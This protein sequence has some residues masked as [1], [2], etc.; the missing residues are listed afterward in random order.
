[1]RRRD[2]LKAMVGGA[3]A[4]GLPL[5]KK[6]QPHTGGVVRF[7]PEKDFVAYPPEAIVSPNVKYARF[8]EYGEVVTCAG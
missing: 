1:M 3:V 6:Q 2:F 8:L 4:V 5:P 7:H